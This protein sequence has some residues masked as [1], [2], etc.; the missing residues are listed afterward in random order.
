MGF[1]SLGWG[2]SPDVEILDDKHD[3]VET[4]PKPVRIKARRAPKGSF[5]L[6]IVALPKRSDCR[7]FLYPAGRYGEAGG[8]PQVVWPNGVLASTAV[9]IFVQMFAPWCPLRPC[10][11][12]IGY[13]DD[14]LT[15]EHDGRLAAAG[16][17]KCG[18]FGAI[19]D[20]GDPFWQP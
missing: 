2:P 5:F 14:S 13:D 19:G 6:A 10:N 8:N 3:A 7:P 9:G 16:K 15:L 17:L 11:M 4:C 12:F 1:D 18:H 20:L